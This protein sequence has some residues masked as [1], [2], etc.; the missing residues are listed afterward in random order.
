MFRDTSYSEMIKRFEELENARLKHEESRDTLKKRIHFERI[1]TEI[2]VRLINVDQTGI[3][4]VIADA[5]QVIGRFSQVDRSYVFMFSADGGRMSNTHE[6]C[7]AD[8]S[9]QQARLQDLATEDFPWWMERLRQH[10]TI[11]IPEVAA[12]PDE[13]QAE[14]RILEVQNIHS[15]LVVPM[16]GGGDLIGFVGFDSVLRAKTWSEED[17]GMLRTVGAI[18]AMAFAREKAAA[19]IRENEATLQSIFLAAPAGIGVVVNQVIVKANRRLCEMLGYTA[20]ELVGKHARRLY[21]DRQSYDQVTDAYQRLSTVRTGLVESRWRCRDGRI[22]EVLL[23]SAVNDPSDFKSGV[24][25]TALDITARKRTEQE[26]RKYEQIVAASSDMMALVDDDYIYQ[27]VNPSYSRAFDRQPSEIVGRSVAEVLGRERF[28]QLVRPHFDRCL[29]GERVQYEAWISFPTLGR[30]H[31]LVA[32]FPYRE[33]EAHVS[34]VVVNVRDVTEIKN[35]ERQLQQAQKMEALGTLAGGI[36]HDFNNLL[37]GIQGYSS[38][39]LDE[40]SQADP[41]H[42]SLSG[43]NEGVQSAVELTQQLLG[44]ARGGR[45]EVVATDINTLVGQQTRLFGRTSKNITIHEDY[46]A[47]LR[48][49][50]VDRGQIQQALLNLY[51]NAAQA[52]ASGGEL[53]I[54]TDNVVLDEESARP[55]EVTPGRYVG[56]WVRD[57][58]IGIPEKILPKIFDPFFSTKPK[59]RGTGLGLAST[60]GIVKNHGGCINVYSQAGQGA[61]FRILLPACDRPAVETSMPD[62]PRRAQPGTV[63]VV[64]DESYVLEAEAKMLQRLGHEVLRAGS[65]QRALELFQQRQDQ[66][67]FVVLDLVMPQMSGGDVFKALRELDP[68]VKILVASGFSLEEEGK[69]L[70]QQGGAQIIP[71]PFSLSQLSDKISRLLDNS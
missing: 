26:L 70:L 42:E 25:F 55:F 28:E 10:A 59:S 71:K 30:R 35:L 65:G 58:G 45:Y 21:P 22:I 54:K 27:A 50:E 48:T 57:T 12:M 51:I 23:S 47:G 49:A 44:L 5:L 29:S 53:F 64:D 11:H 15:V 52:M 34:G 69:K 46:A 24:T 37:S 62:A 67:D 4:A 68:A 8:I 2:A 33:G 66:I 3:D 31:M 13:A 39:L 1:V 63:L 32:Y 36:A 20:A 9:S 7:G 18:F 40:T 16:S 19:T 43:I 17:I 60:Y 41:R 38:L 61:T 6:W 14:R 56:I